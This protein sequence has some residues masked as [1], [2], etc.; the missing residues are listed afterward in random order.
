MRVRWDC[1]SRAATMAPG[2]VFVRVG[3][4]RVAL[5]WR[6]AEGLWFRY[7]DQ[8]L[9]EKG[10][11]PVHPG[12]A[13]QP[14]RRRAEHFVTGLLPTSAEL[15]ALEL[16]EQSSDLLVLLARVG[17]DLP[18]SISIG[19]PARGA[20]AGAALADALK[21]VHARRMGESIL[22]LRPAM[23]A[24]FPGRQARAPLCISGD[25][26][27]Y[28]NATYPSTHIVKAP[29]AI[30]RVFLSHILLNERIVMGAAA[31]LGVAVTVP[32]FERKPGL[33]IYRRSDRRVLGSHWRASRVASFSIAQA[34]DVDPANVRESQGGPSYADAFNVIDAL[35][36]APALDKGQ[37]LDLAV[38]CH[39]AGVRDFHMGQVWMLRHQKAW[40]LAPFTD[41]Y[42]SEGHAELDLIRG[43][44][45][46]GESRT[47]WLR[48]DHWIKFAE[49]LDVK[50]GFVLTKLR[51][52]AEA[53]PDAIEREARALSQGRSEEAFGAGMVQRCR[54]RA[55]RALDIL[56]MAQH[57]KTPWLKPARAQNLPTPPLTRP[58][59]EVDEPIYE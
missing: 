26:V 41:L 30:N 49:L 54:W 58:L 5:L 16:R 47:E 35:S 43:M 10:A 1:V 29:L 4:R 28:P 48:L 51:G 17:G 12:F 9:K 33:L 44:S 6:D 27:T 46:A 39:L 57:A 31:G 19:P 8:Y 15:R 18:G 50:P 7:L 25:R 14:G 53:V 2:D 59:V 38:F 37:L 20:R 34:K 22:R 13:L 36:D 11:T 56:S 52:M 3:V 45:I 24:S 55:R 21:Q 23:S 40:R 32:D 42:D